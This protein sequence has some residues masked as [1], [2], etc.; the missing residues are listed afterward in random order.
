M[1]F[2]TPHRLPG[3]VC[4][5][6]FNKI[7]QNCIIHTSLQNLDVSAGVLSMTLFLLSPFSRLGLFFVN[8][9]HSVTDLQ[10]KVQCVFQYVV[11]ESRQDDDELWSE[12]LDP[13]GRKPYC[14]SQWCVFQRLAVV[15]RSQPCTSH[16][17]FRPNNIYLCIM[18]CCLV[19]NVTDK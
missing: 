15:I 6:H 1:P 4:Q 14:R 16:R 3:T 19:L 10:H 11:W 18:C 13:E 8:Y 2:G 9:C 7:V 12:I 5:C 17:L